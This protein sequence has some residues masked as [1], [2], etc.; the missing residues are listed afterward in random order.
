M[1]I[2]KRVLLVAARDPGRGI[3][4]LHHLGIHP[5]WPDA[6]G[7]GRHAERQRD[8]RAPTSPWLTFTPTG[9]AADDGHHHL[10]GRPGRLP[11]VRADGAGHRRAG[12]PGRRSCPCRS[13]W[14]CSARARP[15]DVIKAHPEITRW[16]IGGHS[17]GGA[18]SAKYVLQQS[19]RGRRAGAVG[20]VSG[21]QQQPGGPQHDRSPRSPRRTTGWQRPTRSRRPVPLPARSNTSGFRSRVAIT[22]DSGIMDLRTATARR[23]SRREEQ[24]AQTV[25]AT[26]QTAEGSAM[27]ETQQVIYS[28]V[29][30]GRVHPAE[31]PGA[32]RHLARLLLR[33]QDRRAR[34]ERRG[35]EHA[36]AHHGRRRR[37]ATWAKRCSRRATP[38]GC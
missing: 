34:P 4:R 17:L 24:Q 7:A 15:S 30:V 3:C 32:A 26:V 38:A 10:P 22:R 19:R 31:P 18:M 11:L 28:M 13:T 9:A 33:R 35:Q 37:W 29:R 21:G 1:R 25:A 12:L 8:R 6:G 5:P 36:A 16:A 14:R 23:P 27:T 20:R 2:F